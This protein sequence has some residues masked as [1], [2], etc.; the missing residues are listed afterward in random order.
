MAAEFKMVEKP[1]LLSLNK[2]DQK[3]K[4]GQNYAETFKNEKELDFFTKAT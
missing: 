2:F 3:P 1:F 4:H